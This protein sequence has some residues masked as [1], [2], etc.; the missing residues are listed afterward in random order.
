MSPLAQ[1]RYLHFRAAVFV[2]IRTEIVLIHIVC[3]SFSCGNMLPI[4]VATL[5]AKLFFKELLSKAQDHEVKL[6]RPRALD[7]L[8]LA[9]LV[10][11]VLLLLLLLLLMLLPEQGLEV[12]LTLNRPVIELIG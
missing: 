9:P 12:I 11:G 8:Q 6:T 4:R 2:I 1:V 7:L 3:L 10:I 5:L